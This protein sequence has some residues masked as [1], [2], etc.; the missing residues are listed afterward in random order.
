MVVPMVCVWHMSV[1]VRNR[2]MLVPMAVGTCRHGFVHMIMMPIVMSVSVFMLQF[3]VSMLMGMSLH[4]VQQNT[5]HHQH[6]RNE[7]QSTA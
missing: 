5:Q 1:A 6:T 2:L 7:H 3:V 4:Q